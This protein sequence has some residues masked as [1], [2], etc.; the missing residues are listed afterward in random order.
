MVGYGELLKDEAKE[1]NRKLGPGCHCDLRLARTNRSE[2]GKLH[3]RNLNLG[4]SKPNE[5]FARNTTG[6][7]SNKGRSQL[8]HVPGAM[9]LHWEINGRE[10]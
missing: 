7:K 1:I 2:G 8:F 9:H 5:R 6:N 3:A 4:D 10:I